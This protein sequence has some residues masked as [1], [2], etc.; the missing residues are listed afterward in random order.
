MF[1]VT[2]EEVMLFKPCNMPKTP[3]I[4]TLDW[5]LENLKIRQVLWV[6][7]R[8]NKQKEIIM[9][10]VFCARQNEHLL[11]S[12]SIY[13]I[14]IA[15]RVAHMVLSID[16]LE[17]ASNAAAVAAAVANAAAYDAAITAQKQYLRSLFI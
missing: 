8:L 3:D 6:L 2:R 10:S 15:E 17:H 13:A 14:N 1:S 5:A 7:G 16:T 12:K 11:C 4:I 9:F